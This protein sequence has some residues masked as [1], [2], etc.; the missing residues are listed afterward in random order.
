MLSKEYEVNIKNNELKSILYTG[1]TKRYTWR[2]YK[3]KI[4]SQD[5]IILKQNDW[6]REE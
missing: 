3:L 6:K 1:E 2:R 4:Q 5:K